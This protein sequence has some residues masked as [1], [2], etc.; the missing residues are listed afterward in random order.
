MK[1]METVIPT[2]IGVPQGACSSPILFNITLNPLLKALRE[3]GIRHLAFADDLLIQVE[4]HEE[5]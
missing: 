5:D 1:Y 3:R 2:T 4:G